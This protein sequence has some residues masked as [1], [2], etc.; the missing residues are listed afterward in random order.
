M[1]TVTFDTLKFANSLK[2]AGVPAQQAEAM[3]AAQK[4]ALSEALESTLATKSDISDIKMELAVL[5]WM[6]GAVI[7]LSI[8]NFSKQFF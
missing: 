4:E 5:K 6:V 2:A 1:S 7:A 8:A 3:A